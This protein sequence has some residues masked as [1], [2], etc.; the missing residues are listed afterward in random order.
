MTASKRPLS[1]FGPE[2]QSALVKGSTFQVRIPFEN[3]KLA[4]RFQQRVHQLR[5]AMAKEDHPDTQAAYRAG[6]RLEGTLLPHY[7]TK[8]PSAKTLDLSQPAWVIIEPKDAEFTGAL[9]RAG[10]NVDHSLP[11]ADPGLDKPQ[12]GP[13]LDE[14]LGRLK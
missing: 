7:K 5:V 11:P 3:G 6:T 8:T 14:I 10:V 4:V 1:S 2:I 12:A 13:S 9:A